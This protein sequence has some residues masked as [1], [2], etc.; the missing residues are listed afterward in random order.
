MPRT[1]TIRTRRKINFSGSLLYV[2]RVMMNWISSSQHSHNASQSSIYLDH[3]HRMRA[4]I[5][6]EIR[7]ETM[8]NMCCCHCDREVSDRARIHAPIPITKCQI[9]FHSSFFFRLS[10]LLTFAFSRF[11]FWHFLCCCCRNKFN[12]MNFHADYYYYSPV[13]SRCRTIIAI[14]AVDVAIFV[15]IVL[16]CTTF[17]ISQASL[18]LPSNRLK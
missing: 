5:S 18:C 4:K 13:W 3:R 15:S 9:D 14:F 2:V 10:V 1:H 17:E 8:S 7:A 12:E 11:Y 6:P 16:R